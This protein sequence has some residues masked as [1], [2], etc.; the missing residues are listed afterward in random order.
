MWANIAM[1]YKPHA[2]LPYLIVISTKQS[3]W[4]DLV[5][6]LDSAFPLTRPLDLWSLA[7][8][9]PVA[10]RGDRE[11][12]IPAGGRGLFLFLDKRSDPEDGNGTDYRG[13]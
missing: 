13:T 11:K 10:F 7:K 4:R 5:R 12:Q 9:E 2:R 3:A 1:C 6:P 8:Q